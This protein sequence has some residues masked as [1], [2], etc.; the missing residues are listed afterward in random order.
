MQTSLKR[1]TPIDDEFATGLLTLVF[2][3]SLATSVVI[4]ALAGAIESDEFTHLLRAAQLQMTNL[5]CDCT[6][7]AA[8]D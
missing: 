6:L 4:Y 5:N 8:S 1:T 2:A 7:P 3:I